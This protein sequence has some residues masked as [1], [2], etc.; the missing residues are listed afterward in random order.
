MMVVVR[1]GE[2]EV[3]GGLTDE[4]GGGFPNPMFHQ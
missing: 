4:V 1:D 2:A 3:M